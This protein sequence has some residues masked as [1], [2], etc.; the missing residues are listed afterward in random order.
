M[1]GIFLCAVHVRKYFFVCLSW[2]VKRKIPQ[3]QHKM[4]F[5]VKSHEKVDTLADSHYF[6]SELLSVLCIRNGN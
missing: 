3:L 6:K 1:N 4:C 5:E 2:H